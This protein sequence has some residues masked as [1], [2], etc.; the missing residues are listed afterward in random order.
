MSLVEFATLS[1]VSIFVIVDPV[2][3]P[4]VF[5]GM[6]GG[7]SQQDQMRMA[8]LACV[9][10]TVVLLGFALFGQQLLQLFHVSLPAF[11]IAG[12]L[13][14]LIVALDMLQGR[15]PAM[16]ET[17][18]EEAAGATKDDIAIAPLAV[19]IM[20]G[21]GAITAV[22]LLSAEA[23]DMT[24]RA[25]VIGNILVVSLISFIILRTAVVSA[26]LF[27]TVTLRVITR[28]M[29]LI[30]AAISV[31]FILDGIASAKLF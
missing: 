16:R 17:P 3:L 7:H 13:I 24:H 12:G 27:H 8:R 18:E 30:L 2:A 1:F 21:P 11:Q 20:A 28:L 25:I 15:R 31:Q 9:V 29:G 19:P 10:T 26:A 5:L 14:L 4:P 6:T 23:I 22:V